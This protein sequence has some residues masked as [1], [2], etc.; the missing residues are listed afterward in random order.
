MVCAGLW[1]SSVI[2][3]ARGGHGKLGKRMVGNAVVSGGWGAWEEEEAT[4][5]ERKKKEIAG[6][7]LCMR[8]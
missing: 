6:E 4:V 5:L 8:V 1:L 2:S 3:H 7:L